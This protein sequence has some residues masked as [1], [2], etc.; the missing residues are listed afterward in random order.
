MCVFFLYIYIC[1]KYRDYIPLFPA[2]DREVAVTKNAA[3]QNV[4]GTLLS[5]R[6]ELGGRLPGLSA[7]IIW[8]LRCR[9]M[10]R[11]CRIVYINSGL[12]PTSTWV[13]PSTS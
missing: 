2:K 4:S 10:P 3:V 12:M 7:H 9:G 5:S 11:S 6:R 1:I 13:S 8:G